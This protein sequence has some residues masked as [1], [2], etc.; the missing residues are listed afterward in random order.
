MIVGMRLTTTP[1]VHDVAPDFARLRPC[2][3]TR[4]G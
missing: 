2:D 1:I 4:W 3:T